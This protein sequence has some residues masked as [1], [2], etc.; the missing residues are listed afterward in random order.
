LRAR[1]RD[2]PI[3]RSSIV[4]HDRPF[5]IGAG[6]LEFIATVAAAAPAPIEDKVAPLSSMRSAIVERIERDDLAAYRIERDRYA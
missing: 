3:H 4:R 6:N 5:E 1:A 2:F